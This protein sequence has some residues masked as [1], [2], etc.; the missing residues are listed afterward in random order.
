MVVGGAQA[1]DLLV[2]GRNLEQGVW[3]RRLLNV[4]QFAASAFTVPFDGEGEFGVEPDVTDVAF[5][6]FALIFNG[7]AAIYGGNAEFL[8]SRSWTEDQFQ[9]DIAAVF[10]VRGAKECIAALKAHARK[11]F[12]V[13]LLVGY[14]DPSS[15]RGEI[16][17]DWPGF[18]SEL[19]LNPHFVLAYKNLGRLYR[20]A[21]TVCNV[22][23]EFGLG[24]E[25]CAS[26]Q[27]ESD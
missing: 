10:D 2:V 5:G 9:P 21:P 11:G 12:Q 3:L 24:S 18:V 14:H 22:G 25:Q 4:V 15:V 13:S 26:E 8:A 16:K 20:S 23:G 1:F 19:R 7:G 6:R 27:G 17:D